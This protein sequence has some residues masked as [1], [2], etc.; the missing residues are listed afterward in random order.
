[1]Y[2]K[3]LPALKA[4][5][6]LD[7]S[8][9]TDIPKVLANKPFPLHLDTGRWTSLASSRDHARSKRRSISPYSS[10]ALEKRCFQEFF[11]INHTSNSCAR[12]RALSITFYVTGELCA[13]KAHQQLTVLLERSLEVV[14]DC[15]HHAK[16]LLIRLAANRLCSFCFWN[17]QGQRLCAYP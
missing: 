6:R 9:V 12:K 11:F 2:T 13:I 5:S 16:Y 7:S 14:S 1:M 4:G 17:L 8:P 15:F 10:Q 3:K